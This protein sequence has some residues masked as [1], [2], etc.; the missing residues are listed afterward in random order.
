MNLPVVAGVVSTVVFAAS[1]M[2]M[3]A[4][5]ARTKDLGSY[6]L[7]HISLTNAGNL[8]HSVYVFS[9]PPGPIWALH[10]FYVV[11]TATMLVW[12][13]RYAREAARSAPHHLGGQRL[14]SAGTSSTVSTRCTTGSIAR[15]FAS[16]SRSGH[17]GTTSVQY[18]RP[19]STIGATLEASA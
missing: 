6:S 19:T 16:D 4:K 13:V 18:S 3:L 11:T 9:L 1:M 15:P 14:S 2:P 7:G 8:V 5:A 10:A 17:A 12:Y